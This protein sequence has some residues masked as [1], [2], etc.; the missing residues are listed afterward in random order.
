MTPELLKAM[1]AS[2]KTFRENILIEHPSGPRRFGEIVEPWQINDF[3]ALDKAWM[4]AAGKLTE[5]LGEKICRRAYVER[6]RGHSK[7]ADLAMQVAWTLAFSPRRLDGIA[8]ATDRSDEKQPVPHET[9]PQKHDS[10]QR[11]KQ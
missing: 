6:S 10:Q 9:I 1:A 7:T 4:C 3:A 11:P 5:S 8:A 2:P